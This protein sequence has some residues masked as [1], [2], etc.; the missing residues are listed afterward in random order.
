M[1]SLL[2]IS[3]SDGENYPQILTKR[4]CH[5]IVMLV[6]SM[7]FYEVLKHSSWEIEE[8]GDFY[9]IDDLTDEEITWYM[10]MIPKAFCL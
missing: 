8:L 5:F 3:R 1:S 2:C 6:K 4:P 7:D 10:D 9:D